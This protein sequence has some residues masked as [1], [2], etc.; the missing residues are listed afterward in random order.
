MRITMG[1]HRCSTTFGRL[2]AGALLTASL[3]AC[4]SDGDGDV[5]GVDA[6]PTSP[7][8][9]DTA[10]AAA[11]SAGAADPVTAFSDSFEDDQHGWALPESPSGTTTIEG[12][13]FVW[14]SKLPHLRPH[15][16]AATLGA[17]YDQG[18]LEMTD[19]VVRATVTPQR[20]AGAMGVF[21][22]EVPDTDADFQWYEF[23]VRDGYAAI[24]L[25][26]MAGNL[27]VLAETDDVRVELGSEIALEATCVDGP[28]GSAALALGLDGTNVVEATADDPLGN[29]VAGLQAYD[30]AKD[31][32]A[33]RF[34]I[35]WHAFEVAPAE[36]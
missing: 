3:V 34:L 26:D 5:A 25:A 13:D 24:R 32:S 29:G 16:I 19:V 18:R 9:S 4:S 8:S 17:A 27:D 1:P 2:A 12:G 30:A 33:D 35:A 6:A 14:E 31:E 20:G 22:R 10:T 7:A 28:D 36:A 21:C 23:V 11:T 15:V